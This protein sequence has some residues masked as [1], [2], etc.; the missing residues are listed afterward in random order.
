MG[1]PNPLGTGAASFKRL[2]GRVI[3]EE[4]VSIIATTRDPSGRS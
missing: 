1:H 2:L 4:A 3:D